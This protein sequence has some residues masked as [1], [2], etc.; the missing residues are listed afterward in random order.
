MSTYLV[1]FTPLEPYFFGNERSFGDRLAEN[2]TYFITSNETPSQS[3]LLGTLR[4]CCIDHPKADFSIGDEDNIGEESFNLQSERRQSFGV[5]KHI[6]PMFL[7]DENGFY[8]I[9]VPYNH[10]ASDETKVYTPFSKYEACMT[11]SGEQLMP[12]DYDAKSGIAGGFLQING[13]GKGTVETG[14][15]DEIVRIGINKNQDAD[16]LFRKAFRSLKTGCSFAVLA[17]IDKAM[18][19]RIVY[20]GKDK[21][22]FKVTFESPE[23]LASETGSYDLTLTAFINSIIDCLRIYNKQPLQVAISDVYIPDSIEAL[24]DVCTFACVQTRD[25]RSLRTVYGK[26]PFVERYEKGK[27]LQSMIKAGSFFNARNKELSVLEPW[28]KN[29]N[30]KNCLQAGY[31]FVINTGK[32]FD[33]KLYL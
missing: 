13:S 14:F 11:H 3:S 6:S 20:M 26:R 8:Y 9:P 18:E 25:Y 24:Y 32:E 22:M 30:F 1:K 2:K 19:D 4:Y 16:G 10:K 31:N 21:S 15:I 29:Y 7:L 33:A 12:M 5:I 28:E 23:V 17:E 27:R